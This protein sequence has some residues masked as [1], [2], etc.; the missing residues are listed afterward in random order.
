M[1]LLVTEISKMKNLALHILL[2]P[3]S[4]C[5]LTPKDIT[6]DTSEQ[7]FKYIDKHHSDMREKLISSESMLMGSTIQSAPNSPTKDNC[8]I[9][10][11]S[12]NSD[13]SLVQLFKSILDAHKVDIKFHYES[14][15]KGVHVCFKEGEFPS[16]FLSSIPFIRSVEHDTAVKR[17]EVQRSAPW[18]LDRLDQAK[19][20]FDDNY[21]FSLTGKNVTIYFVDSGV[22]VEHPEFKGR[23][24]VG[25]FSDSSI[26]NDCAGHGTEV[27]SLAAGTNVGVAKEAKIVVAQVLD[28]DG[29]GRNSDVLAALDWILSDIKGPAVINMS[30][31]GPVS[32]A[33]NQAVARAIQSGVTVVVA[34]GNNGADACNYSPSSATNAITVGS[35]NLS[36]EMSEFSNYGSCVDIFAPGE[37]VLAATIEDSRYA[38]VSGTSLSSPM[39][40]GIAAMLLQQN[41]N[42]TPAQVKS[43]II[44]LASKNVLFYLSGSPNRMAQIPQSST[45]TTAAVPL[46]QDVNLPKFPPS[47]AASA[48]STLKPPFIIIFISACLVLLFR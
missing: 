1:N 32:S 27:S 37:K 33:M 24:S 43:K 4:L 40:S 8:Y 18:A 2:L 47:A 25:Y 19:L 42:L 30:V 12:N 26:G 36:D 3:L 23:A 16:Q 44:E 22:M 11:L 9:V 29:G 48:S 17:S 5:I 14:A 41:P 35:T 7:F 10:Q 20:P 31:G 15:I 39:V 21:D 28:C 6:V 13:Q 34:A 46:D 38:F 45:N